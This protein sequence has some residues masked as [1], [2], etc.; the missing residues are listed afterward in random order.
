MNDGLNMRQQVDD[1]GVDASDRI[2]RLA[3][4]AAEL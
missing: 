1:F 2:L 4:I 3:V